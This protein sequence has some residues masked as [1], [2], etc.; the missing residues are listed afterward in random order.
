ML[1]EKG[2]YIICYCI[3]LAGAI[4]S[5]LLTERAAEVWAEDRLLQDRHCIVIDAGHGGKDGGAMSCTGIPES[6]LNLEIALKLNDLFHLLGYSTKMIRSDD[7]SVHTRG[8][9]LASQKASDLKERVKIVNETKNALLLSI[10]QNQF[11]EK[12]YSGAQVFYNCREDSRQLAVSMQTAFVETLNPG[13]NRKAKPTSG[14]YLMDHVNTTAVLIEC[15]FISNPGEEQKLRTEEYQK[16][17]CCVI[18][19]TVSCFID[20]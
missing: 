7:V 20:A 5:G 9:T 18:A 19:S 2:R 3:I 10:H 13:S 4:F 6:K 11:P 16:A 1:K 17:I 14:V 15:G 12:K 8:D